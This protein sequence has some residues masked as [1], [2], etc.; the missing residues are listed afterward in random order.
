MLALAYLGYLMKLLMHAMGLRPL[1]KVP[2]E[3]GEHPMR[4]F[5]LHREDTGEKSQILSSFS[6]R[7]PFAKISPLTGYRKELECVQQT[8]PRWRNVSRIINNREDFQLKS[9]GQTRGNFSL[10]LFSFFFSK[11]IILE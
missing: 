9:V 2:S 4:N 3:S 1:G 7:K 10:F 11:L 8:F 6:R 5:R